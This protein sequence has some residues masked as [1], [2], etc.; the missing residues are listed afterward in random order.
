[1]GVSHET[2]LLFNCVINHAV[3]GACRGVNFHNL[4][5]CSLLRI[6]LLNKSD[7]NQNLCFW[8]QTQQR[9][10]IAGLRRLQG[11][12]RPE[13]GA[14]ALYETQGVPG[15]RPCPARHHGLLVRRDVTSF[16]NCSEITGV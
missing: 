6:F 4:L 15:Q 1:M 2:E 16:P 3:H 7:K 8:Q 5:C 14:E 13:E 12:G 9:P 10:D 11:R